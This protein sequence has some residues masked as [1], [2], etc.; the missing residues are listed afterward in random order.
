MFEV[1]QNKPL[2]SDNMLTGSSPIGYG[3]ELYHSETFMKQDLGGDNK[4]DE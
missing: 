2:I 1:K 4:K 3:A